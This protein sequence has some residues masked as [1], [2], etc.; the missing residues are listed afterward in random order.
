MAFRLTIFVALLL[1]SP[2]LAAAKPK[3]S[4]ALIT[5]DDRGCSDRGRNS[6]QSF[7][8]IVERARADIGKTA[9]QL[10]L[11][12]TKWC[13]AFLRAITGRN[14]VDDRA[15]SWLGRPHTSASV[16]SI[17]IVRGGHHV[18]VVS[19]FDANGNPIL[20]SGNHNRRVGEGVYPRRSVLAYVSP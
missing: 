5:C 19:G 18:G 12:R 10:G 6:G 1:L 20:I 16:G 14:D 11:R 8:G 15:R 17:A 4:P 13:S 2:T 7:G 3:N 9:S